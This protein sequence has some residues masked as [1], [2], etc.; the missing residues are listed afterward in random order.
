MIIS[1]LDDSL[2]V[3]VFFEQ[4]DCTFGDNICV[5]IREECPDDEK[6]FRGEETYV[7]LTPAQARQLAKVLI[8]AAEKSEQY[9]GSDEDADSPGY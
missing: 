2:K 6:I 5:S 1:L 7:Y 9:C 3:N 4:K 8:H